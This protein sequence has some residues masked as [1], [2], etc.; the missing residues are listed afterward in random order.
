M[1]LRT[2]PPLHRSSRA[3]C[4]R[5]EG[6]TAGPWDAR[7]V[8]LD[9]LMSSLVVVR[10]ATFSSHSRAEKSRS[11]G[12]RTEK[13]QNGPSEATNQT[14]KRLRAQGKL[15]LRDC[16]SD[17]ATSGRLRE[18]PDPI[19]AQLGIENRWIGNPG[20]ALR[21][22]G[23]QTDT[24]S[25]H[26]THCARSSRHAGAWP[27]SSVSQSSS[28]GRQA[29]RGKRSRARSALAARRSISVIAASELTAAQKTVLPPSW[30]CRNQCRSTVL[31]DQVCE[32]KGRSA[33]RRSCRRPVPRPT[34]RT[35]ARRAAC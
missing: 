7:I 3:S 14:I 29:R 35:P 23:E 34:Q 4:L 2:A 11:S 24:G 13:A 18:Y 28:R 19:S 15:P 5:N 16:G 31:P 26:W 12:P 6:A 17:R 20:S 32:P 22:C 1:C 27:K 21:W 10:R 30:E 33:S 9:F 25:S 8:A